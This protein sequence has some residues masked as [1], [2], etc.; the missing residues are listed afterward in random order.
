MIN[1]RAAA[2]PGLATLPPGVQRL[3]G[4]AVPQ[5]APAPSRGA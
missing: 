3:M 1:E 4:F 2:P 5:A